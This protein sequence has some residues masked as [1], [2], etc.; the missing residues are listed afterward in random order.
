MAA[1]GS[2]NTKPEIVVRQLVSKLGFRYRLHH[3]TEFGRPDLVFVA[4]KKAI[5]VHGC[6]WHRHSK[7]RFSTT[8]A[9]NRKFWVAKFAE[10]VLRDRRARKALVKNGWTVLTVWEC[11]T[12]KVDRLT[13]VLQC[14]LES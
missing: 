6:F 5:F 7:C 3:K 9:T 14:F 1:I 4:R 13:N 8:P 10:N 2:K 12:R 11:E